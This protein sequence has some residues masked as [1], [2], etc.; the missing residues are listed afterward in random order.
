MDLP[1]KDRRVLFLL[2][3]LAIVYAVI[4]WL[5]FSSKKNTGL[6]NIFKYAAVCVCFFIAVFIYKN[7]FSSKDAKLLQMG[8]FFTLVSDAFLLFSPVRELGIAAFMCVHLCYIRRYRPAIF[9][10]FLIIAA[11]DMLLCLAG[12]LL[13]LN[14]PYTFMLGG[15]YALLIL[16]ATVSAFRSN[17]PQINKRLACIGMA[18]FVL[19]DLCVTLSNLAPAGSALALAVFPLIYLFYIPSQACLSLSAGKYKI[20]I[21]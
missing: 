15:V 6:A 17:L 19:C 7:G 16:T 8:L 5:D 21:R 13:G 1:Q 18:L 2:Y 4:L 14:L 20:S 9:K 11:G 10:T 3:V 12:A